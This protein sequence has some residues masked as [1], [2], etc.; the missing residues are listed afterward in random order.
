MSRETLAHLNSQTLIGYTTKRGNAWHYRADMQGAE[1]NHYPHAIPTEDVHRRLFGWDAL[2]AELHAVAIVDDGVLNVVDPTRKVIVR[3]DNAQILGVVGEGYQVHPYGEW[4]V[5]NVESILDADLRIGSAGVLRGGATAWVQIEM[6]D[7]ISVEGVDFRPFLTAA[8]SLD[9]SLATTYL[10]GCQV[11]VCDNTLSVALGTYDSRM[12]IKHSRHS[13]GR[14]GDVREALGII[15]SVGD[16]FTA[17]VHRLIDET[18]SPT[19]WNQFVDAFTA[20]SSTSTRAQRNSEQKAEQLHQLWL[21]DSRVQPWQGTAYGVLA[22][23]NTWTHHE[24]P[25]R[26]AD[27]A[28]RNMERVI[29]GK[30]DE[31]DRS[32]LAVLATV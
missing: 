24:M 6:E 25:I 7:T 20:P 14:I 26:G 16:D 18:V 32:T 23:V 8:T 15:H 4:L 10:T 12:K 2:V 13:L 3:S 19:R 30:V 1:P 11:V 27:R 22:A 9:G 17:Q 28:T 29:A 5:S 31:L 21:S